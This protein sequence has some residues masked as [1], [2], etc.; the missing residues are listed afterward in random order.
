MM[1]RRTGKHRRRT[2][3]GASI[4][5][6]AP[7]AEPSSDRDLEVPPDE[8]LGRSGAPAEEVVA[9]RREARRRLVSIVQAAV[10]VSAVICVVALVRVLIGSYAATQA[11]QAAQPSAAQTAPAPSNGVSGVTA[12]SVGV[13]TRPSVTQ[14]ATEASIESPPP[15]AAPPTPP[16]EPTVTVDRDAARRE[17]HEAQSALEIGDVR[18]AN[19]VA[20][21]A[22]EH[23]PTDANGWLLLVAAQMELKD[24]GA[25]NHSLAECAKRATRGPRGECVALQSR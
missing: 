7:I 16:V 23:D 13:A 18:R 6:P 2:P 25:A 4:A 19:L 3:K 24:R 10:G 12:V 17:R 9:F 22:V 20:Q 8:N 5:P 21:R 15:S 1:M 11:A 14:A